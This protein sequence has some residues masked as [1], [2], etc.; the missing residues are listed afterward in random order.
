M[1]EAWG[2][3]SNQAGVLHQNHKTQAPLHELPPCLPAPE[4]ETPPVSW[5]PAW[6][7]SLEGPRGKERGPRLQARPP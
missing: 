7:K 1:T 3:D 6:E 4:R 2:T 5:V